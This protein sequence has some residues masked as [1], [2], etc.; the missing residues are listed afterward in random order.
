MNSNSKKF[1]TGVVAIVAGMTMAVSVL[2]P[3][4][5]FAQ[6][7]PTPKGFCTK[8][9]EIAS[10]GDQAIADREA[11]IQASHKERQDNLAK[12]RSEQDARRSENRA[13]QD[14]N[15]QEHYAKL[16]AQATTD[17][18]KQAVAAFK[19]TVERANAAKNT[20]TDAATQ[21]FRQSVEQ[22]IASRKSAVDAAVGAFKSARTATVNKARSD[23]ATGVD[24]G[25]VRETYRAS[26][27]AAQDNFKNDRQTIEKLGDSLEPI[28][29]GQKQAVAKAIAEFKTAM[30]K[31]RADLK[32]AF[33]TTP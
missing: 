25:T 21:E 10:R 3:G 24:Q 27:K 20:A 11:K 31:A 30:E 18:Q 26:M 15:R 8:V 2:S 22:T 32:A 6:G 23:C 4:L 7:T 28:R 19:A 1:F 33:Q 13:R 29:A 16:E 9:D 14:K 17:A 12:R 5:L